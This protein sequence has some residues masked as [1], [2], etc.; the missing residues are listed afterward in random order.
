MK[1]ILFTFLLLFVVWGGF[2]QEIPKFEKKSYTDTN[3]NLYWNKDLPV[4]VFLSSSPNGANAKKL[5]SKVSAEYAEPFY[6]D[7]EGLN[8]MR[9][10]WAVDKNTKELVAP[11]QEVMWEVYADG[12]APVTKHRFVNSKTKELYS[13]YV[14]G[15][16]IAIELTSTDK[17][18][19]VK[20]I[21][22]SLNGEPYKIYEGITEIK[23]EGSGSLK[24]FAVDNVGNVEKVKEIK[25]NVDFTSPNSLHEIKGIKLARG[26]I[27]S[28]ETQI[29]LKS[30]D[31]SSEETTIYYQLDENPKKIFNK[32]VPISLKNLED[33]EHAL[34]YYSTDKAG[35]VE[36]ENI[37]EFYMDNTP[38]ITVSDILGD[39]FIVNEKIYFSGRTKL[40]IT[41]V[42]NKAGV[43]DIFYAI[44]GFD[45]QKYNDPFYMPDK[46]GWHIVRFYAN[47]SLNNSTTG[48][49]AKKYLQYQMQ[50]DK[51]YVDL[52]GPV[53]S[54]SYLGDT[55]ARNDTMYVNPQTKIKLAGKDLEC[56]M[57]YISY[58]VDK[59]LE[60]TNYSKPFNLSGFD[61]GVHNIEYFGYDNVN[62][63]NTKSFVVVIDNKGPEVNYKFSVKQLSEKTYPK[64]ASLFI[65]AQDNLTGVTKIL[66]SL[67]GEPKKTYTSCIKNFKKGKN[68]IEIEAFDLLNNK[69]VYSFEFFI[70]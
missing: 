17:T 29:C 63:R 40:K 5:E 20:N 64:D 19:K 56:G 27:F 66:Y 51:I 22:Y 68:N 47:D 31:N 2:S 9:T 48:K 4:Y 14:Y 32:N 12:T 26:N 67:N 44:D 57:Q 30:N 13:T 58:S 24:Y 65:T 45:F 10:K 18:S 37:Y 60:E 28:N 1:K 43:K 53:L 39:K 35:N 11:K 70:K 38:P 42:D 21:Y 7:S 61:V 25:F 41:S 3:K 8:Y 62:N 46:P 15:L 55:Y 36:K 50:V 33:G 59:K 69:A 6:F 54:H 23:K 52:S 34:K 16:D 49:T